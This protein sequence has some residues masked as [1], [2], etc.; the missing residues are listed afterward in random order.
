MYFVPEPQEKIIG[1]KKH[2]EPADFI[3]IIYW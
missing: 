3:L 2:G 1:T